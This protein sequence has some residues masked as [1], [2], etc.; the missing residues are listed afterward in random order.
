MRDVLIPSIGRRI[1]VLGYGCGALT[2]TSRKIADRLLQTAFDSGIRHF[3]VARYYGYGEAEGIL[4]AFLKSRRAEVTIT[5]KF[6]IQ[7]PRRSS[8]LG[9]AVRAGRRVLRLFPSARK[10]VQARIQGLVKGGAF[11]AEDARSSLETSLRE[12][13]TDHI[14]FY[15][16]HDYVVDDRPIDE[17]VAFLEGAVAAGKV[18]RFGVATGIENVLRA[19]QS[20]PGLCDVLQFEN[21]AVKQ[22]V[23]K[24]AIGASTSRV[25]ITHG[26][27]GQSHREVSAFL[28]AHRDK[29]KEWSEKIGADCSQAFTISAL[30]LNY[31]VQANPGGLVL[32][33][34]MR[35]ETV[36]RNAK[37][38]F[39]PEVTQDQIR[40]FA[41]LV[42]QVLNPQFQT[43][44][45]R[46]K[47]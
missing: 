14:E 16:L 27:V 45:Q 41:Q 3:D 6:G 28:G 25:V 38:V 36:A 7:P 5:T 42:Q 46:L 21:S 47:P 22:N 20:R 10:V 1:P 18:G 31:A 44:P 24:L 29:A 17:L 11:S 34:S 39:D 32:F 15:L 19:L 35:P 2:G 43:E 33:S 40:L 8:A 23:G 30:L 13:G 9:F 26:A 37:A 12:L 4:G